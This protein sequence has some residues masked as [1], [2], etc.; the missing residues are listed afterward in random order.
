MVILQVIVTDLF[1]VLR[2][3]CGQDFDSFI[4]SKIVVI[5]GDVS[6][7]NFG[8]KDEKLKSKMLE[9]INV[10]VN[11]AASTKFDERYINI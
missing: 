7:L 1:R 10:V 5:P 2:D 9:E 6:L 11:F 8:L 3:Q 4:S